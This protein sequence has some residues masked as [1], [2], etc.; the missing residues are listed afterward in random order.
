MRVHSIDTVVGI[1]FQKM[2]LLLVIAPSGLA[3]ALAGTKGISE[4]VVC[5]II[6]AIDCPCPETIEV[7]KSVGYT[8]EFTEP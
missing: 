6:E 7:R 3:F 1:I 8:D 5:I 4:C 2:V